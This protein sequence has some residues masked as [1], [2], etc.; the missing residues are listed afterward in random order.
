VKIEKGFTLIEL[1]LVVALIS[2]G[3]L[4]IVQQFKNSEE[5]EKSMH[6][7]SNIVHIS[8]AAANFKDGKTGYANVNQNVLARSSRIPEQIKS[9]GTIVNLYGG[10]V[11]V[12]TA[13][14]FFPWN[15]EYVSIQYNFV[16]QH[17]CVDIASKLIPVSYSGNTTTHGVEVQKNGMG[18]KLPIYTMSDAGINCGANNN[19]LYFTFK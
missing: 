9:G 1:S 2:I 17:A 18:A 5:Q 11:Y 3:L 19:I 8:T 6:A 7:I 15:N 14:A 16:P 10:A 13:G 4:F 12:G